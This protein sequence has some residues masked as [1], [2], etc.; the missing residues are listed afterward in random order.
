M[1]TRLQVEHPV[2]EETTGKD[3]VHEQLRVAAGE[4]L[5]YAQPD[6]KPRGHSIEFRI[7]AEDAA[8]GYVPTTG[9]I[10]KL[11]AP[12]GE[13]VRVDSGIA[14]GGEVTAAFDPM[15]AKLIVTG[16]DR[17]Q[18]MQRADRA[19]RDYVLLGCKTNIGFLRRLLNHEAF[20]K[21]E[22]HTGFLDAHPEVA[23]EPP[24]PPALER[25]LLS[26]A[27]YHT[28]ALRDV[29]DAV[30]DLHAAIGGWRN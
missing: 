5:G 10:L 4:T 23:A 2:T 19:L 11:R 12:Q 18:A 20:R 13:G 26:T 9:P 16:A 24:P 28:R 7:Y 30:P 29:A 6:V 22:I 17:A 8:R 25:V 3:L 27:A 14:E 21:G 15:L 1:N